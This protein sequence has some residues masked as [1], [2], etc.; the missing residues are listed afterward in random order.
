MSKKILVFD[1]DQS[2]LQSIRYLLEDEG[3]TILPAELYGEFEQHLQSNPDLILLDYWLPQRDCASIIK[4]LKSQNETKHIP[5]IVI[6]AS[7][8]L[9]KL[10]KDSGADRVIQKPFDIEELKK[11][12][13]EVL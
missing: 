3:Y 4:K 10:T 2:I 6:S 5:V 11:T 1:D 13:K 12:I 8:N 9:E 7:S